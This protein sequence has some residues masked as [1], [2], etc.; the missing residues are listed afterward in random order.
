MQWNSLRTLCICD[1]YQEIF[2][3]TTTKRLDYGAGPFHGGQSCAQ[4]SCEKF[5]KVTEDKTAN[6]N[7]VEN[8]QKL[9]RTKMLTKI[10]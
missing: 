6:K 7:S 5:S 3:T 2:S 8:S 1:K 9:L 10:A 4:M